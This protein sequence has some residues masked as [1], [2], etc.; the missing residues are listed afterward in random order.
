M[1]FNSLT[2]AEKSLMGTGPA[3]LA[4]KQHDNSTV[5]NTIANAIES[6]V[7]TEDLHFLQNNFLVFIAEK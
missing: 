7:L 1:L 4:L 2:N 3:A 5:E 6:F